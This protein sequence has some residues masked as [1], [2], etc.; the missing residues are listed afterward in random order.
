MV[1]QRLNFHPLPQD[2]PVGWVVFLLFALFVAVAPVSAQQSRS[3]GS[4][5]ENNG[6]G[7]SRLVVRNNLVYDALL[8]PNIGADL[9]LDSTWS[10]GLNA[11]FRPWPASDDVATKWRHLLIAPE[12]RHWNKTTFMPKSTYWGLN[13]FYSHYNFANLQFPFGLYK[14]LRHNRLEGDLYGVGAFYGYTWRISRLLRMEAELG[15]G[16]GYTHYS[17][18]ECGRCGTKIGTE[19]KWFLIPKIAL[20]IVVDPARRKTVEEQ[21]EQPIV[22]PAPPVPVFA[23][24]T[25]PVITSGDSLAEK[26]PILR[27]YAT[28]KPYDNTRIL[29]KEKGMLYV[30][31]PLDK[32]ILDPAFRNNATT[33]EEIVD[34]TRQV[35][36]DEHSQVRLIQIIGLASIEGT[37]SHNQELSDRRA[38]ALR[39][40]V[41]QQIPELTDQMFEVTGGGEAWTELRDQITDAIADEQQ[42]ASLRR[43][44]E[45]ALDIIDN[46]ADPNRREWLLLHNTAPSVISF[47]RRQL[48]ADQRN[49]GYLH[50]YFERVPDRKAEAI[51]HAA[52]L[53]KQKRYQEALNILNDVREDPRAWNTLGAALYHN[54]R[55][56]EALEYFRRAA[57]NGNADA[58]RNLRELEKLAQYE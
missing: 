32:Y 57:A 52:D 6:L 28:Y 43:Q 55:Q 54:G 13:L 12:L 9:R 33:L 29:R 10:I 42:P 56:Q 34:I 7:T 14:V 41:K 27:D 22:K 3:E 8:T 37:V 20:N 23:L 40:Y 16:G 26:H 51:N 47:I 36:A 5:Y 1:N 46:V 49:S 48:L 44:L 53:L 24:T 21:P 17:R 35:M 25:L 38:L 39:D 18:Y 58:Q 4:R 15:L 31:F 30:H 50:I 2:T 45:K 19:D 11:G